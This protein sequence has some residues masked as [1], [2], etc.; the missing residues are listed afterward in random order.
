M[1][2]LSRRLAAIGVCS[3]AWTASAA[4]VAFN[5]H[6]YEYMD[7][8]GIAWQDAQDQASSLAIDG[9]AGHLATITS[10]PENDLVISL[11]PNLLDVAA[12]L[13]GV[14]TALGPALTDN[15]TWI[16]GETW[17]YTNWSPA[18]PNGSNENYL[19]MWLGG[20]YSFRPRGGWNDGESFGG[21]FIAGYVV[22][23]DVPEASVSIV[24]A[25]AAGALA[26][27]QRKVRQADSA[28]AR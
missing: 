22:E 8:P 21:P 24:A 23:W 3:W 11:L 10:A 12:Y 4:P 14:R 20:S 27:A 5:G 17:S 1:S 2:K 19:D 9:V 16:T 28:K 7:A 15:W 18:E 6:T 13:G 26:L 25:L